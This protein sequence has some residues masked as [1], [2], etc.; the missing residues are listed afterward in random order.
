MIL[1]HLQ[2]A[3][4][5]RPAR[6]RNANAVCNYAVAEGE[7]DVAQLG[8]YK[9]IGWVSLQQ[10]IATFARPEH[11]GP[12]APPAAACLA[13]PVSAAGDGNDAPPRGATGYTRA[14]SAAPSSSGAGA[15]FRNPFGGDGCALRRR[16][17][18]GPAT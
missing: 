1:R 7:P 18:R 10:F 15:P 3:V 9:I 13:G 12:G 17:A 5:H 2:S 4:A 14:P 11:I 16:P 8:H 6:R